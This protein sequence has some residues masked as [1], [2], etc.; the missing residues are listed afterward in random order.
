MSVH[1]G[2]R[3][4]LIVFGTLLFLTALTVFIAFVHLGRANDV[5]ALAIAVTKAVLVLLYF[6]HLRHSPVLTRIAVAAG[7]LWLFT[8]IALTMSD[9]LTRGWLGVP[10]GYVEA[11]TPVGTL[12]APKPTTP[13]TDAQ[14]GGAQPA[15]NKQDGAAHE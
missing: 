3:T 14:P 7:V 1:V 13:A 12:G 9:L 2:M 15:P 11:A 5:V 8:L 6:M 4:Y 10:T